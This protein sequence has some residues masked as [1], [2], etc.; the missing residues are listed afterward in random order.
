MNNI[1]KKSGITFIIKIFG[2]G[3]AFITQIL[4]ARLLNPEIYGQYTL[5]ITYSNIFYLF[6]VLGMDKNLI[7]EI[8]KATNGNKE[9]S[10]FLFTI[11]ISIFL[12]LT[13]VISSFL[14]LS[15]FELSIK[16]TSFF[17]VI[18]GIKSVIHIFDGYLQGLGLIKKLLL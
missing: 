7:K 12:F 4:F 6:V 5:I 9:I 10:Y 2:L 11:K 1:I 8:G 15:Y 13:I 16:I 18:L 3:L 17:L 14:A